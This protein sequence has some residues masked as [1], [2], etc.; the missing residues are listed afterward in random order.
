MTPLDI[1]IVIV[2]GAVVVFFHSLAL[3][4]ATRLMIS[5]PVLFQR[6]FI[7]VLLEYAAV[8]I[9]VMILLLVLK[10]QPFSIL[11]GS[12][13]YLFTGA[14]LIDIWITKEGERL[15]IGN[16][17]LIQ[18]IQIPILVPLIIIAWLLYDILI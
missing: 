17:V 9:A 4:V 6:A 16:G 14:V 18:A 11:I 13:T 15:G 8:F 5:V 1:L 12:L 3:R 7:I 10:S 2:I